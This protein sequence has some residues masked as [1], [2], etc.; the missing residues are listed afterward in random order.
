LKEMEEEP[1]EE[2]MGESSS[3]PRGLGLYDI[4]NIV[5]NKLVETSNDEAILNPDFKG[6]LD[7]HFNRLPTR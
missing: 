6:Q 2:G 3:P 5:Y 7:A 4:K 1:I